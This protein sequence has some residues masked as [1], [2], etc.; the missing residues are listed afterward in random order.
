[1]AP[2][3]PESSSK[4]PK[5][6]IKILF[7]ATAAVVFFH[8]EGKNLPLAKVLASHPTT[9]NAVSAAHTDQVG[10]LVQSLRAARMPIYI[11]IIKNDQ[12][13]VACQNELTGQI[14]YL[15]SKNT[16]A[17]LAASVNNKNCAVF[18]HAD[19]IVGMVEA[20]SHASEPP[21]KIIQQGFATA[22][23]THPTTGVTSNLTLSDSAK[24][25]TE[26]FHH[27]KCVL[28]PNPKPEEWAEI[29]AANDVPFVPHMPGELRAAE[30]TFNTLSPTAKI[31][32]IQ[33][34][35]ASLDCTG[36]A[37]GTKGRLTSDTPEFV[38]RSALVTPDCTLH[39][40]PEQ[41]TRIWMRNSSPKQPDA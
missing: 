14:T 23:C 4:W 19:K 13:F 7:A 11:K 20:A 32:F 25:I 38:M 31:R 22:A 9:P 28:T 3:T 15:T 6:F 26:E 41:L 1:M 17:D 18:F 10:K 12:A 21:T 40:A 35:L 27:K 2:Q 34:D 39:I 5:H 8:S 36:A 16:P 37:T 30:A 33:N 29:R 24:A